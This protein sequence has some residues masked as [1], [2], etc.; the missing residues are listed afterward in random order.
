MLD[1]KILCVGNLKEKYWRDACDEYAKRLSALCRFS[2][3]QINEYRLPAKPSETEILKGLEKEGEE[4]LSKIPPG[5]AVYA[6]C[7]EGK[8]LSSTEL[9]EGISRCAV[10]GKSSMV[11]IIGSSCGLCDKIKARADFKL[12]MSKMTFPHQLARVMLC[13]QIY[14]AFAINGNIKYH[15]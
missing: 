6:M 1:V 10:Q 13:E 2:I 14:R 9:A 12:S 4:I 15:K 3:V 5:A 8:Q 7:I 11:F